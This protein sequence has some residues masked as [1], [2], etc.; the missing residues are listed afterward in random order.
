MDMIGSMRSE[1]SSSNISRTG[2]VMISE[3]ATALED[4]NDCICK[5]LWL[6]NGADLIAQEREDSPSHFGHRG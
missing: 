2:S 3:M 6:T 4:T 1:V 5:W